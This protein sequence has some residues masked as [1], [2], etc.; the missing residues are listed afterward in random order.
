MAKGLCAYTVSGE[1]FIVDDVNLF[2]GLTWWEMRNKTLVMP[3]S[4]WAKIK[5]FMVKQCKKNK[6]NVDI[7]SWDRDRK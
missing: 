7:D 4:S 2:E 6:C 1:T 5:A 3:A